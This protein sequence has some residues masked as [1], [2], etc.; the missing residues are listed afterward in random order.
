M[1]GWVDMPEIISID[2][3]TLEEIGRVEA[4]PEQK[5][6]E[7]VSKARAALPAWSRLSYRKRAEHI[8]KAREYLLDNIDSFAATITRDN[9][10]PVAESISAEILPV[11]DLLWWAAHNAERILKH[12]RIGI[13]IFD[14]MLRRSAV[15][16]QPL[17]VIGIIS[18]WNYPFSIPVG[19]TAMALMA[20][21]CVLLKPSS[22]TPIVGNRIEELFNAAGLPDF[23]FTHIPGGSETGETLLNSRID[24]VSFTGSVGTGKHV[25]EVCARNLIPVTL[26]LGGKDAAIVRHDADLDF[27][28]SAAVWGAFTN[29]GQC[30]ASI[31]RL[32]VHEDVSDR[33]I[34]LVIEKTSRLKIGKGDEPGVDIGPM[35]TLQQLQTVE[36]QVEE[37]KR[38]GAKILCGGNKRG[39]GYFFEPTVITGVDHTFACVNEE[40]FGPLLPIMTF[41]D[42]QQAV[43]LANY[44]EYGLNAYI[45]T[46]DIRTGRRMAKDLRAGTIVIND[47]VYT[48]AIPQTPWGGVKHSGFGRTHSAWG[49][50]DLTNLHHIHINPVTF[51]KDFWWYPYGEKL[52]RNLKGLTRNLTGCS[53]SK[54]RAIPSLLGSVFSKKY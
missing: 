41:S 28:S 32:Y 11:A 21:N 2:P 5:V 23:V 31:E 9:G 24:K 29:A 47:C 40:T 14:L 52:V 53:C 49:F 10:K 38:R 22:A 27:A 7:Y 25:A 4:T 15:G 17:G 12:R 36:A 43:Q 34:Q 33:F 46:K 13:G 6:K 8:L 19:T 26:E 16:H 20:G 51:I 18:P 54:I 39:T 1:T 44:S 50:Y 3:A 42:D 30:C 45:F 37:V 35:T 48:H